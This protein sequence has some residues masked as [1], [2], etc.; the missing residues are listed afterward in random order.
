MGLAQVRLSGLCYEVV[1]MSGTTTVYLCRPS[2]GFGQWVLNDTD[3]LAGFEQATQQTWEPP[4]MSF[5]TSGGPMPDFARIAGVDGVMVIRNDEAANYG[6]QFF[7][8]FASGGQLFNLSG[9]AE[10]FA[11]FR[12]TVWKAVDVDASVGLGQETPTS[13]AFRPDRVGEGLFRSVPRFGETYCSHV[14]DPHEITDLDD[15]ANMS[16]KTWY[17]LAA[18]SGFDFTPIWQG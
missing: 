8:S 2:A 1:H 4:A 16:F 13:Y 10:G 9:D 17:E 12:P 15:V 7:S 3:G 11:I 6:V 18:I 5:D 14:E